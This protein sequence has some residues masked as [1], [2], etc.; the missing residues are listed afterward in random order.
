MTEKVVAAFAAGAVFVVG[1]NDN[2][3]LKRICKQKDP[4][5]LVP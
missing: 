2:G 4:M 3:S 1:G 5:T